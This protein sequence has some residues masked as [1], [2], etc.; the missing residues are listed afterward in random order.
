MNSR[1]LDPIELFV[2]IF[3]D[4]LKK[5]SKFHSRSVSDKFLVSSYLVL[6]QTV[7]TLITLSHA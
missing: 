5:A 4:V 2:G 6:A 1:H 3:L 7:E